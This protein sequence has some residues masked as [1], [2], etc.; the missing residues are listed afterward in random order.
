VPARDALALS[1]D[2]DMPIAVD[3]SMVHLFDAE[4]GAP[5]R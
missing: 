4:S 3:T 1:V 2:E 5:L